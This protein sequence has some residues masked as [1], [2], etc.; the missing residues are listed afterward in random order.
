MMNKYERHV[1][2]FGLCEHFREVG[3]DFYRDCLL[4]LRSDRCVPKVPSN[5]KMVVYNS[6]LFP[7]LPRCSLGLEN[8]SERW[9]NEISEG[10][11]SDYYDRLKSL[12]KIA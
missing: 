12:K 2:A 11:S 10:G 7:P 9:F 6:S 4:K 5:L 3:V 8:K 1:G